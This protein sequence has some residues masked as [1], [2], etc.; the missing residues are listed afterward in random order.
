MDMRHMANTNLIR[1][2]RTGMEGAPL[3]CAA[4]AAADI[5]FRNERPRKHRRLI[6]L[7]GQQQ[8]A[9]RWL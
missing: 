9:T 7:T 6:S 1:T 3:A 2:V 4:C 5:G 8:D